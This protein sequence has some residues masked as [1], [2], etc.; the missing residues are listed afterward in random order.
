MNRLTSAVLAA[1]IVLIVPGIVLA[2]GVRRGAPPQPSATATDS[3][4]AGTLFSGVRGASPVACTLI[5][6]ALE[7]RWGSRPRLGGPAASALDDAQAEALGWAE[8]TADMSGVLPVIR[9]MLGDSDGCVRRIAAVLGGRLRQANL[10]GALAGELSSADL[11]TREAAALSLGYFGR[12]TAEPAL[13]TAVKDRELRVRRAAAWALGQ[14]DNRAAVAPLS[15]LLSDEDS[16]VRVNAALSLG[17]LQAKDAI[18]ALATLLARDRDPGVRRAAA[19]AL[20]RM[21]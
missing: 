12:P 15:T 4:K 14:T 13:A 5:G 16:M 2:R 1:S 20:G 21:Q 10:A 6:Q 9:R 11:N 19:A 17:A 3:A 18:P 8:S 7:N